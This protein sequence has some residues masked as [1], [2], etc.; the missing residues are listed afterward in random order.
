MNNSFFDR[1]S[2]SDSIFEPLQKIERKI[3]EKAF[4]V[5]DAPGC[6][7]DFYSQLLDWNNLD[8][9]ILSIN[10]EIFIHKFESKKTFKLHTE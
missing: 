6:K 9:I 2:S 5:L 10:N 4:K 3:S 8:Q 1:K 7:D